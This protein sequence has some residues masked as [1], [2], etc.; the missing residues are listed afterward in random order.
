MNFL[1]KV[2]QARGISKNDINNEIC[3]TIE[4]EFSPEKLISDFAAS[5][6][7]IISKSCKIKP[8]SEIMT[9]KDYVGA[10]GKED[11]KLAI[12][13]SL[14][15]VQ[16]ECDNLINICCQLHFTTKNNVNIMA[17]FTLISD[18]KDVED[19][20]CVWMD[21]ETLHEEVYTRLQDAIDALHRN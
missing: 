2:L 4:T 17:E 14:M 5:T 16:K 12:V 20:R 7:N 9:P 15:Q 10:Y 18:K 21:G 6:R 11:Y 19:I 3:K 8:I 1:Q 13:E